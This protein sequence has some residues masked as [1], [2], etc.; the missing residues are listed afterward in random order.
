MSE[1]RIGAI[2]VS[3]CTAAVMLSLC[4]VVCAGLYRLARL[5]LGL[6]CG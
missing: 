4:G 3:I 2:L 6:G 1:K 5:I